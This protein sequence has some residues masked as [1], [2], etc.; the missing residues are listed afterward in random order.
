MCDK[1]L[2]LFSLLSEKN[3]YAAVK[4]K[5]TT[6][7]F[8]SHTHTCRYTIFLSMFFLMQATYAYI[9]CK[10]VMKSLELYFKCGYIRFVSLTHTQAKIKYQIFSV[11][12]SHKFFSLSIDYVYLS[13]HLTEYFSSKPCSLSFLFLIVIENNFLS[14]AHL[15][16]H[17]KYSNYSN[18]AQ[19]TDLF[20][21][22]MNA[23]SAN[24]PYIHIDL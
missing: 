10:I 17:S 23:I 2:T 15:N 12:L 7:F 8:K 4:P 6:N 5:K 16:L 19:M 18:S 20:R 13:E 1:I 9:L 3:I 11:Y 24:L 21:D 22:E 14:R